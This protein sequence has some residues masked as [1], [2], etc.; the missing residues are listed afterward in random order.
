MHDPSGW[1]ILKKC[2]DE[3]D[4]PAWT[5]FV[6][7]FEPAL[8]WGI[9]RALARL[10]YDGDRRDLTDDSLQ[11]CYCKILGRDRHVLRLC[12]ERDENALNAYFS[13]L[14]ERSTCDLLRARWAE[15]RGSRDGFVDLGDGFEEIAHA[16]A[17]PSPE[18]HAMIQEAHRRLLVTC[19]TAA[20]SRQ[21]ERNY[22]VLVMAF[23][24]G[25]TSREISS[26]F[27]GKLSLSCIDSVVY[28]ARQKLLEKGIVLGERRAMA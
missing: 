9:R 24:E 2:V 19:R 15:K 16:R 26:R 5:A 13:R 4:G 14:A 28:R 7:R 3:A 1:L 25:L 20:G 18:D 23:L 12:R 8:R 22:R 21:K 17:E 10:G 11:E 27:A 6:E